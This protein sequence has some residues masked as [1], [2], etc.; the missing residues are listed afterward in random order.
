MHSQSRVAKHHGTAKSP[1]KRHAR[2]TNVHRRNICVNKPQCQRQ[3]LKSHPSSSKSFSTSQNQTHPSIATQIPQLSSHSST[4]PRVA[5]IGSGPSALYTAKFLVQD[6][7]S[8]RI[9]IIDKLFTPFG[10]VRNGIAPD[11]PEAKNVMFDFTANVLENPNVTFIGGVHVQEEPTEPTEHIP[12]SGPT[13]H[14]TVTLQQLYNHYHAVV[15]ATGAASGRDLGLEHE[16]HAAGIYDAREFVSWYNGHP[17][18]KQL[19]PALP[20][21]EN[22]IIIGNGNV[23]ID[24]A[25]FLLAPHDFLHHTDIPLNIR[26]ML[27]ESHIKHVYICARRGVLDSAYT[28]AEFREILTLVHSKW[29]QQASARTKEGNEEGNSAPYAVRFINADLTPEMITIMNNTR[30]IKRKTELLIDYRNQSLALQLPEQQESIPIHQDSNQKT[31]TFVFEARPHKINIT[32]T[33]Q[34]TNETTTTNPTDVTSMIFEK[35]N[36]DPAQNNHIPS[37]SYFSLPLQQNNV[38][39]TNT[40]QHA[41]TLI[42]KSI[43]YKTRPLQGAAFDHKKFIYP[44][45]AGRLVTPVAEND[46]YR[47]ASL[48]R[49]QFTAPNSPVNLENGW[50]NIPFVYATGWARR[51][52]RGIIATNIEDG[53]QVANS[54][55]ADLGLAV[56]KSANTGANSQNESSIIQPP[57]FTSIQLPN[58]LWSH[59]FGPAGS[60]SGFAAISTFEQDMAAKHNVK[61]WAVAEQEE[62]AAAAAAAAATPSQETTKPGKRTT[63][64]PI[65]DSTLHIPAAVKCNDW[66]HLTQLAMTSSQTK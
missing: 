3:K 5:I 29:N 50:E 32:N 43:G 1:T 47:N 31:L 30:P 53:R 28:I 57:D 27:T 20:H 49:D 64:K 54:I 10:L 4:V 15:I 6:N 48:T 52:P 16:Q 19:A 9:D 36:Y 13:D 40:N 59:V 42:I 51:G 37:S 7:P 39:D 26:E 55:L 23:S 18:Y 2:P 63:A 8:I 12:T 17:D 24:I 58:E 14:A 35:M 61:A 38:T 34:H 56:S 21:A 65:K 66:D 33:E 22:A 11:H 44:T 25:R 62:E 46:L 60:Q 45:V 41:N